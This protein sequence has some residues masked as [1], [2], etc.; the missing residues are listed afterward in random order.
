MD[1]CDRVG[2]VRLGVTRRQVDGQWVHF[3][4]VHARELAACQGVEVKRRAVCL[5]CG[6]NQRWSRGLCRTCYGKAHKAGILDQVALPSRHRGKPKGKPRVCSVE[7]CDEPHMARGFCARHYGQTPERSQKAHQRYRDTVSR[8][9]RELRDERRRV[10][11]L[12][13]LLRR[14]GLR[15]PDPVSAGGR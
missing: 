2:C 8:L 1:P 9:K 15:V 7:G 10:H 6:G 3:C 14:A 11:L 4:V 12:E 13:D 5:M